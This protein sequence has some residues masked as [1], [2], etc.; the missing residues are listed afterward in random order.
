MPPAGRAGGVYTPFGD[1]DGDGV[2]DFVTALPGVNTITPG[3]PRPEL[4]ALRG[5]HRAAPDQLDSTAPPG[6]P[7][8]K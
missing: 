7:P 8:S 2:A 4:I 1:L 5:R 3:G 6:K